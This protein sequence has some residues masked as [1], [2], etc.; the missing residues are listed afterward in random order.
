MSNVC[1]EDVINAL[2]VVGIPVAVLSVLQK[3]LNELK[4]DSSKW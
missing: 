3:T 1:C 2:G 4:Q